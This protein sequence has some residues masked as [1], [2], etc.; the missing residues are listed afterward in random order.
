[1]AVEGPSQSKIEMTDNPNGYTMVSYS[2]TKEG[3]LQHRLTHFIPFLMA[4]EGK[5]ILRF[6]PLEFIFFYCVRMDARPAIES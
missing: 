5:T 1:V 2:V 4:T 3:P 6:L